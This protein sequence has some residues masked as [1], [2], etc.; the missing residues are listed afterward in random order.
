MIYLNNY[1]LGV[2]H[3]SLTHSFIN[4]LKRKYSYKW[5]CRHD[6][7]QQ[8]GHIDVLGNRNDLLFILTASK[9]NV[10]YIW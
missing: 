1:S 7:K 3:Q 10:K 9:A 4:I 5:W 8:E 6:R 2:K